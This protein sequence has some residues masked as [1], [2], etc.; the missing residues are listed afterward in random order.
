[1]DPGWCPAWDTAWQRSYRLAKNHLDAGGTLPHSGP[2]VLVVQGED[3]GAWVHAQ[4]L[5][6][7]K[8]GTAQQW[9]LESVLGVE[10]ASEDEQ[11]VRRTQND[12]WLLNLTAAQRFHAREG[13]LQ[14][15]RKHTELVPPEEAGRGALGAETDGDGVPVALG[16]W[17]TNVRRRAHKLTAQRRN[18][19]NQLGI[20]W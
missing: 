16:M 6:W 1:M 19:L 7:N 14:V 12:K 3:L 9:L 13:H 17:L 5:G 8:L 15:P 2:G 20:R 10:E 4:R 18:D 11:P